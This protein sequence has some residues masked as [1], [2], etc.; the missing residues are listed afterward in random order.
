MPSLFTVTLNRMTRYTNF[1]AKRA[2]DKVTEKMVEQTYHDVPGA[3]L[4]A[5][6]ALDPN[7]KIVQQAEPEPDRRPIVRTVSDGTVFGV[8]R[9]GKRKPGPESIGKIMAAKDKPKTVAKPASSGDYAD[10]VNTMLE[11]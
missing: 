3:G 2:E 1:G 6:R 10:L 7:V 5:Y 9:Q 4:A 11:D 8:A